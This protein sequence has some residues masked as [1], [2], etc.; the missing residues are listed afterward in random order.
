MA[1]DPT[2]ATVAIR[3]AWPGGLAAETAA[4]RGT[5]ALAAAAIA[6]C[7]EPT[8]V[9]AYGGTLAAIVERDRFGVRVELP[10]ATWRDGLAAL[11]ACLAA[12]SPSPRLLATERDRLDELAAAAAGSALRTG[13]AAFARA[14]YGEHPLA[15]ELV[16]APA[17]YLLPHAIDRWLAT[18]YPLG[19]AAIAAVGALALADLEAALAPLLPLLATE[20]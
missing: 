13:L 17:P 4:T 12:P 5:T 18:R 7:G 8:V 14:Q 16:G 2:A 9:G 15:R 20:A 6:G 19:R 11:A 3:I 10:V 1:T